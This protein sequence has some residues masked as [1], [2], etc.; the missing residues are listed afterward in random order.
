MAPTNTIVMP[1][2]K[3]R[4]IKTKSLPLISFIKKSLHCH[5]MMKRYWR[6]TRYNW[7]Q[8]CACFSISEMR[9]KLVQYVH[10]MT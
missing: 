1:Q 5:T 6:T 9:K 4:L 3:Y 10:V 7:Q 2:T 8:A